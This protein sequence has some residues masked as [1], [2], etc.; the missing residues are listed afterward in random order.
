MDVRYII[1]VIFLFKDF[2]ITS[3]VDYGGITKIKLTYRPLN[4][5]TVT[6]LEI[7]NLSK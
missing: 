2:T 7:E 4:Y 3:V 5:E 6:Y 1:S